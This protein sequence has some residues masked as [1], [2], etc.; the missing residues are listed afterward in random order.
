MIGGSVIL[1]VCGVVDNVRFRPVSTLHM[2]RLPVPIGKLVGNFNFV[3]AD[4]LAARRIL[5]GFQGRIV[6]WKSLGPDIIDAIRK[7]TVMLI[8]MIN[9]CHE[10]LL[11][12]ALENVATARMFPSKAALTAKA[13]AAQI[14]D[15]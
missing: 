12:Q 1:S 11:L 5:R 15:I 3:S 6:V 8:D 4:L 14:Q 9:N 2:L 13:W 7:S 10:S